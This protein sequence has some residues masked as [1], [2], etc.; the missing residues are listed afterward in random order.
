MATID[1]VWG[2]RVLA[3]LPFLVPFVVVFLGW[4][5]FGDRPLDAA[6]YALMFVAFLATYPWLDGI[7]ARRRF[8]KQLGRGHVECWIRS[9]DIAASGIWTDWERGFVSFRAPSVDFIRTA[10]SRPPDDPPFTFLVSGR[11]D[12][13]PGNNGTN[14]FPYL[15]RNVRS[16]HLQTTRGPVEIAGFPEAMEQ[17]EAELFP[18][19]DR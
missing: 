10:F 4:L 6:V 13:G 19:N 18:R 9:N 3:S 14:R 5:A 15:G 7:L 1:S 12:P 16:V 11:A 8:R 17:L 2:R